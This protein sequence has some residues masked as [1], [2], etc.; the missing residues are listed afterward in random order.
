MEHDR[1]DGGVEVAKHLEALVLHT[2]P[3][4]VG[5][6]PNACEFL[7]AHRASLR[8][9]DDPE[10]GQGLR[11]TRRR[12]GRRE[13]AAG[14]IAA[15]SI[16]H[17]FGCGNIAPS[18]AKRLGEGA[19]HHLD[20]TGR[21]AEQLRHS[22]AGGT[23]SADGVCLIEVQVC[24][25]LVLQRHDLTEAAEV[26]L[27]RIDAFDDDEDLAPRL[28]TVRFLRDRSLELSLQVVHIVV[29]ESTNAGAGESNAFDEGPV[30]KL[31]A[32]NEDAGTTSLRLEQCR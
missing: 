8:A 20:L 6:L 31:I 21:Y 18:T 2:P 16:D 9:G 1:N 26:P 11:S 5:V 23:D 24:L 25:V 29:L 12:H 22:T 32:E 3:E 30:I 7:R 28:S 14:S 27:H 4:K 19:H 17:I 15:K 10:G 13:D